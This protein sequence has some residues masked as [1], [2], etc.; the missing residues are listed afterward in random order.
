METDYLQEE[1]AGVVTR[2]VTELVEVSRVCVGGTRRL[3]LARRGG[4]RRVEP[5]ET[6][7]GCL[8]PC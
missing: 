3:R 1:F 8:S 6:S 5:V 2:A 7:T 4:R